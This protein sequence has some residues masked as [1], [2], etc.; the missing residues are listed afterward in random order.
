MLNT[1]LLARTIR[2]RIGTV[3]LKTEKIKRLEGAEFASRFKPSFTPAS[4]YFFKPIPADDIIAS[5][6]ERVTKL[7]S[8]ISI[9]F[10]ERFAV[11][12]ACLRYEFQSWNLFFVSEK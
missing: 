3:D 1:W 11:I 6:R 8:I 2:S 12:F 5:Q 9:L 4:D 7:I 10:N